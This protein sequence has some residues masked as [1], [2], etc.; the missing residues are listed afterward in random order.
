MVVVMVDVSTK[1]RAW[2]KKKMSFRS[3][4]SDIHKIIMKYIFSDFSDNQNTL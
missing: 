2:G 4:T 3:N 1:R